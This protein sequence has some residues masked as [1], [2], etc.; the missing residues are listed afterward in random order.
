MADTPEDFEAGMDV[1]DAAGTKLGDGPRCP[2]C[3]RP[4]G[5]RR[6][7][8]PY[9]VELET[10]GRHYADIAE[11]GDYL[12]VSDRFVKLFQEHHLQ[13][14]SDFKPVEV[15]KKTYRGRKP[16]EQPPSYFQALIPQSPTTIDQQASGYGW[17]DGSTLCPVCLRATLLKRYTGLVLDETTWNGDDVF[18]PRG[19]GQT[20]VSERFRTLCKDYMLRGMMCFEAEHFAVDFYPWEQQGK[21]PA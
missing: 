12:V 11:T 17:G 1:I 5:L 4:T 8:P 2:H 7:L 14:L 18:F 6:W 21:G 16:A 19:S 3:G 20:M 13:G 9:R 15:V 10:W